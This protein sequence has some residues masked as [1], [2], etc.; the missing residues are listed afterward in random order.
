MKVFETVYEG[1]LRSMKVYAVMVRVWR[2]ML[3]Y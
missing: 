2:D 1:I 3:K